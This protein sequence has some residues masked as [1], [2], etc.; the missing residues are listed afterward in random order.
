MKG[1]SI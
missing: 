1:M